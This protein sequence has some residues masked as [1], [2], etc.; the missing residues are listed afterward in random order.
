MRIITAVIAFITLYTAA[1]DPCC[2]CGVCQPA[3]GRGDVFV[4]SKGTTC[5]DKFLEVAEFQV[6]GTSSCQV[7]TSMYYGRCC[8]LSKSVT[9]IQ[10]DAPGDPC[11]KYPRSNNPT[12]TLC[13]DGA[14]PKKPSTGTAILGMQ[15][16]PSCADLY[17]IG[18]RGGITD[19][20]CN[21]LQDYMDE[22]CGCYSRFAY[23]NGNAPQN[24]A[25]DTGNVPGKQ[26]VA[27]DADKVRI[28]G[29]QRKRGGI[30]RKLKGEQA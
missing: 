14:Y 27:E 23:Q 15:G 5:T 22:P 4:D 18:L 21:P 9:Q 19:Q 26:N 7:Q 28:S 3:Q 30:N 12:C 24:E 16:N 17:C 29:D 25:G 2:L 1:A 6:A 13:H 8:D 20:M 11:E 10:Q